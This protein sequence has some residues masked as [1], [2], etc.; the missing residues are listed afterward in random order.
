[1]REEP[2]VKK[3]ESLRAGQTLPK[4]TPF[5]F[6]CVFADHTLRGVMDITVVMVV[7][8]TAMTVAEAKIQKSGK[9][10]LPLRDWESSRE[11]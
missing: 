8:I 5:Y 2:V 10:S 4:E 9:L 6:F 1:M 3:R 7:A 11:K